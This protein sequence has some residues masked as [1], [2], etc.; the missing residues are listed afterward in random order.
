MKILLACAAG[1]STSL[2]VE[3]M[4]KAAVARGLSVEILALPVHEAETQIADASV[5][6]LGPQVRYA[7]SHFKEV[8]AEHGRPVELIDPVAYGMLNGEKVLDQALSFKKES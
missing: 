2:L 7:L 8:G 1:M 4:K 6:L 3:A 5:V